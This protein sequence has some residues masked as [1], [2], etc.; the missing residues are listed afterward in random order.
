MKIIVCQYC[1]KPFAEVF[2]E[3][4]LETCGKRREVE[5]KK[6]FKKK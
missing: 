1:E 3:K 4:H 6:T 5:K 2:M